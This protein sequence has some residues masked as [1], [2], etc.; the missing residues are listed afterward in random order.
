M[1]RGSGANWLLARFFVKKKMSPFDEK[2]LGLG[3]GMLVQ[4]G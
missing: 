3:E 2:G 1:V 4:W